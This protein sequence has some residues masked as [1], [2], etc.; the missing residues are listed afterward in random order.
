MDPEDD[1]STFPLVKIKTISDNEKDCE[2]YNYTSSAQTDHEGSTIMPE[3]IRKRHVKKRTYDF[4]DG[5]HA[6]PKPPEIQ[7][8]EFV[9]ATIDQTTPKGLSR[10]RERSNSPDHQSSHG[11]DGGCSTSCSQSSVGSTPRRSSSRYETPITPTDNGMA[12]FPMP[13]AKFQKCVLKKL[14]ELTEEVKRTGGAEPSASSY[15][16][17][18]MER[19]EEVDK[20]EDIL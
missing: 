11:S 8:N 5:L 17:R 4:V 7:K 13:M 19:M 6:Y 18:R 15:H 1:W 9:S 20:L 14:V 10:S 12:I 16:V 2:D 3:E